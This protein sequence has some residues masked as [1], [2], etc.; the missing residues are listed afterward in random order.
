MTQGGGVPDFFDEV[1]DS[2]TLRDEVAE[3]REQLQ[4]AR[5]EAAYWHG[6]ADA[7]PN[8]S[9]LQVG[10]LLAQLR[11]VADAVKANAGD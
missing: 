11:Q 3:L 10:D 5:L 9:G 1:A 6:R 7:Q 2:V 8:R 4:Q